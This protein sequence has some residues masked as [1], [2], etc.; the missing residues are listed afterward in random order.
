MAR[1]LH[2]DRVLAQSGCPAQNGMRDVCDVLV[3]T[4][5][6]AGQAHLQFDHQRAHATHAARGLF[7]CNLLGKT[8]EMPSERHHAVFHL[9]ANARS[10]HCGLPLQ[11]CLHIMLEL[12]IGLHRRL[13]RF[14]SQV[15]HWNEP[16]T[17]CIAPA[18]LHQLRGG[19]RQRVPGPCR[20]WL[21]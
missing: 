6:L 20:L 15:D 9:H 13:R 17:A 4:N 21:S 19:G 8:R 16:G 3:G 10:G 14:G 1:D 5:I 2:L 11:F 12:Q 7:S 18:D